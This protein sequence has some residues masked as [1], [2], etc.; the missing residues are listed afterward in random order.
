MDQRVSFITLG[1]GD[2]D[3]SQRFYEALGWKPSRYAEGMGVVFFELSGGLVLA[4]YPREEL[5][6]DANLP[7]QGQPASG[8]FSLSYNTKS[9]AEVDET[10]AHV[11]QVGGKVLKEPGE[12]FWGGYLGYFADPDGHLW[13]VVHNPQAEPGPDGSIRLPSK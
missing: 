4:L 13:E 11:T 10:M 3:R 2:L 8:G 1:V 6:R 9:R 7:D 5:T 12:I